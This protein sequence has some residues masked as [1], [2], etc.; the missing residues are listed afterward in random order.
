M[1]KTLVGAALV[2]ALV[3]WAYDR[4]REPYAPYRSRN[5]VTRATA[6][7]AAS[8]RYVTSLFAS[9]RVR[10]TNVWFDAGD[11]EVGFVKVHAV[12]DTHQSPSIEFVADDRRY[13]SL[14]VVDMEGR[15]RMFTTER[16]AF[17]LGVEEF[18]KSR[19]LYATVRLAFTDATDAVRA[20]ALAA[21]QTLVGI[22]STNVDLEEFD[23]SLEPYEDHVAP[24]QR[25][26]LP[27][28]RT[29][30]VRRSGTQLRLVPPPAMHAPGQWIAYVETD[31]TRFVHMQTCRMHPHGS[32]ELNFVDRPSDRND[33]GLGEVLV[34]VLTGSE[35]VRWHPPAFR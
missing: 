27:L 14:H 35:A 10:A 24:L 22:G 9:G 33:L 20:R 29:I 32:V 7:R 18:P 6:Q 26:P 17:K 19:Y 2:A 31:P 16:G 3:Y 1:K 13:S 34:F 21:R 25:L 4:D 23:G 15:T 30:R 5:L 11:D 28:Q 8:H 12:I